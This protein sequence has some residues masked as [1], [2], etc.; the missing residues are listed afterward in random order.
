[1]RRVGRLVL[2][3]GLLVIGTPNAD[4]VSIPRRGNPSLHPPYH[5]HLLSERMLLA[6]GREQGF[7]PTEIYRRSFYDSLFPTVNSRFLWRYMEKSGGLLDTAV[8]PPRTGLVLR[9]P[10][11]L[12]LAFF[13][14]FLSPGDWILV[15]F[16]KN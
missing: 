3:G 1:M 11:L 12:F 6:L 7:E 16:R 9:S 8:E 4:R 2:P 14:Y 10:E 13:G 5:R 15:S